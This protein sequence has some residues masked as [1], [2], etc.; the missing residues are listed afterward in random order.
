VGG[1][2]EVVDMK[3]ETINADGGKRVLKHD[4]GVKTINELQI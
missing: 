4:R 2:L 1:V 3:F